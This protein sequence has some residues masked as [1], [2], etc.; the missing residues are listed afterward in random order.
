MKLDLDYFESKWNQ[1]RKLAR[2]RWEELTEDDLNKLQDRYEQFVELLQDKYGYTRA[3]AEDE[4]EKWLEEVEDGVETAVTQLDQTVRENQWKALTTVL[5][6]GF[7]LGVWVGS[8][9]QVSS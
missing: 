3:K 1:T 8:N 4:V 9:L 2:R 6:A 7:A 5:V